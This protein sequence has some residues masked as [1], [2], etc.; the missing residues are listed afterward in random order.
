M[1]EGEKWHELAGA[2]SGAYMAMQSG[3]DP[4]R[5]MEVV[6]RE[7]QRLLDGRTRDKRASSETV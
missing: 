2:V 1:K 6:W 5:C 3:A 7:L 4:K